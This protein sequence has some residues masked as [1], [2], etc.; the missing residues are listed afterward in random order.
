MSLC[1]TDES[2][3]S[4][5]EAREN[6]CKYEQVWILLCCGLSFF[7]LLSS[8]FFLVGKKKKKKEKNSVYVHSPVVI[9]K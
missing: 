6:L 1:V 4:F 3:N 2:W 8:L 5:L 9:L 7:F